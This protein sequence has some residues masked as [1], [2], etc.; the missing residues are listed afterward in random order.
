MK[1]RKIY[2]YLRE[3]GKQFLDFIKANGMDGEYQTLKFTY[4]K[5]ADIQSLSEGGVRGG[6]S[7]RFKTTFFSK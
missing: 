4:G 1:Q 5:V 2:F 7:V 3:Q 6:E